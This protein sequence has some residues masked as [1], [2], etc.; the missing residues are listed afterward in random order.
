MADATLP[1]NS[2]HVIKVGGSLLDLPDLPARLDRWLTARG[3]AKP[4]LVVGGGV[5]AD[6]HEWLAGDPHDSAGDA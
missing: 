2:P 6:A 4:M 3:G 5:V 1:D